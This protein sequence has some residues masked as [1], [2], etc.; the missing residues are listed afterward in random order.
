MS[1]GLVRGLVAPAR[2]GSG[3]AVSLARIAAMS[4]Q[5]LREELLRVKVPERLAWEVSRRLPYKVADAFRDEL[6]RLCPEKPPR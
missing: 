6:R 3:E 5:K 4:R 2:P 1:G